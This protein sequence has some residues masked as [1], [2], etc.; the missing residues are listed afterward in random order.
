MARFSNTLMIS[1]DAKDVFHYLAKMEN[2]TVWNYAVQQITKV[3]STEGIVGSKYH[4]LRGMGLQSFEEIVITEYVPNERL[5]FDASGKVFSYRMAYELEQQ[6]QGTLLTNKAEIISSGM[7]GIMIG[8]MKNNIK[9]AVNQNLH[10]L[11]SL[12]DNEKSEFI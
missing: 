8:I 5:T 2:F 4:L 9:K 12:F 1:S 3:K 6:S 11:K 10:V 7:K